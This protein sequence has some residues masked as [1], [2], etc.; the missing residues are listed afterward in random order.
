MGTESFEVVNDKGIT[1]VV[2]EFTEIVPAS[3]FA[4]P[5]AVVEGLKYY[6]LDN[7]MKLNRIS[8]DLFQIPGS[9]ETLKRI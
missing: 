9:A 7:G 6:E 1:Y 8:H 5:D 3:T 2:T 4:D